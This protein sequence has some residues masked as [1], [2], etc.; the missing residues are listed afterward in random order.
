MEN[1]KFLKRRKE[2]STNQKLIVRWSI[3][4]AGLIALFWAVWYLINGSVPVVNEIKM[5]KNW[6]YVLPF[7]ISR[8]WDILIGPIWSTI[9]ILILTNKRIK[10]ED[11]NDFN[12]DL[13]AGLSSGA[14]LSLVFSGIMSNFH[15]YFLPLISVGLVFGILWGLSECNFGLGLGSVL[16]VFLT[17]SLA[18]GIKVNLLLCSVFLAL[19]LLFKTFVRLWRWLSAEDYGDI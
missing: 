9:L 2:M 16:G 5:T 8:W 3:L 6:T 19:M 15:F 13:F 1:P 10:E 11:K 7:G 17:L 12:K 4:T 18:S 14:V